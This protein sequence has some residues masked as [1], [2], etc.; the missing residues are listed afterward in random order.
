[1]FLYDSDTI[2]YAREF[3]PQHR[4]VSAPIR[5]LCHPVSD[6]SIRRVTINIDLHRD[7]RMRS[8]GPNVIV[9]FLHML[10]HGFLAPAQDFGI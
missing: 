7:I 8:P 10:A 2:Q 4:A 6:E 9:H 3:S 1:M 5:N